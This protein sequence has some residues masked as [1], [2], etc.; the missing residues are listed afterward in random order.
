[1]AQPA[2]STISATTPGWAL[3]VAASTVSSAASAV[4]TA[5][6][7]RSTRR[8]GSRSASAPPTGPRNA[9]GTNA[10][11]ATSP[12]HPA[13]LVVVV[14]RMPTPTVS[15]H[16]PTFDVNAPAHSSAKDR[17]RNGASD[18]GSATPFTVTERRTSGARLLD[19]WCRARREN[20]EHEQFGRGL[21]VPAEGAHL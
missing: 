20:G 5:V 4:C 14:T 7:I 6:V 2:P 18:R 12:V 17:C 1:M 8:R 16:V 19:E 13:R 10:A 11:A 9:L 21:T 3:S 15:I